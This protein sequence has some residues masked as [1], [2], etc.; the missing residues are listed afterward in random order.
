MVDRKFTSA[1]VPQSDSRVQLVREGILCFYSTHTT[2]LSAY[3]SHE[4][5]AN[6][7]TLRMGKAR[8][9]RYRS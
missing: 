4:L 6:D 2:W 1:L 8:P 7:Q 3:V 5:L 9:A